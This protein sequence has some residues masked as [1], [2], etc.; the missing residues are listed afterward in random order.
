MLNIK[1]RLRHVEKRLNLNENPITVNVVC[2]GDELPPDRATGNMTVHFVEYDNRKVE[3][4][5]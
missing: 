1:R 5:T 3:V 2:F 4:R